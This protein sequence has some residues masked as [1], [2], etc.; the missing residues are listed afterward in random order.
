[1]GIERISPVARTWGVL[2]SALAVLASVV[3]FDVPQSAAIAPINELNATRLVPTDVLGPLPF[4]Q[5]GASVAVCGDTAIVGSP[6]T[7][8]SS[9]RAG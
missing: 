3:A 8:S 6:A 1:M 9:L 4:D 2:L 7:G 5:F